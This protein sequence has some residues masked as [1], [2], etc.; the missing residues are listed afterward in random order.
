MLKMHNVKAAL[1]GLS[2]G[3]ALGVPVEFS[4]RSKM[5][6]NPVTGMWEFGTW[7]QPIG[8]W[9]DD[10]SLTIA[11]MESI[12]RLRTFDKVDVMKNFVLWLRDDEFTANDDAFD[13]GN[14]TG[15]AIDNFVRG[16]TPETCG[17]TQENSNGNG[18]LMRIFPAVFYAYEK[19]PT[20]EDALKIVHEFS[21]LTHAHEVSQMACGIY[22]LICAQILDGQNLTDA[23]NSGLKL[24]K[25]FYSNQQKFLNTVE[26]FN[27]LFKENFAALPEDEIRS[28]GYVVATL[29]SVIWCLH[30]TKDY[31]S[32]ALTAVNLGG[33]TD[34]VGAIA[35]G[36]GGLYYGLHQ[37][38]S[39][40]LDVLKR[41]TYLEELAE[42]FYLSLT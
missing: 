7:N 9:S 25:E 18:S 33:D 10:T 23:I 19:A 37:I 22:Y 26:T 34:T 1:I 31:K 38:P 5:K 42:K 17:L 20:D 6:K 27:R 24:A 8:T 12:T 15:A 4:S 21:A 16:A 11:A 13:C 32:L 3:D 14:T 28:T 40:W 2:V 41:R 30:N 29:E 35:G 39:E 36:I